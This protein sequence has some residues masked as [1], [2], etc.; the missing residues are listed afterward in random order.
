MP[1]IKS[2]IVKDCMSVETSDM[3]RAGQIKEVDNV[4]DK[5]LFDLGLVEKFDSEIH[6][7]SKDENATLKNEITTLKT[8]INEHKEDRKDL[9]EK[10]AAEKESTADLTEK[11]ALANKEIETLKKGK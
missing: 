6:D 1:K 3:L 10:L 4:K 7:V 2:Y 5:K 11:L 8:N 9:L